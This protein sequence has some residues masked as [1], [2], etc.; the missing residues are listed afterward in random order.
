MFLE[1][2]AFGEIHSGPRVCRV[3]LG[4]WIE[5]GEMVLLGMHFE[6]FDLRCGYFLRFSWKK[7]A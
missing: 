2:A 6:N 1:I 3:W 4:R 5:I 7:W